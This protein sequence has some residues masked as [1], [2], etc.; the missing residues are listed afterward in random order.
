MA[1]LNL[2]GLEFGL[3]SVNKST[4]STFL[5]SNPNKLLNTNVNTILSGDLNAKISVWHTLDTNT[6]IP[7]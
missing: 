7:L 1:N 4:E 5:N 6:R 2:N 3:G